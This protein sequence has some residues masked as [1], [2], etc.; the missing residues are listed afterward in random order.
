MVRRRRLSRTARAVLITAAGILFWGIAL[1]RAA[2]IISTV[3]A[4]RPDVW[5]LDWHV[6]A[7]GAAGL[8]DRT[9]HRSELVYP[10]QELPVS[11]FN[12]PPMSA[13]WGVPLAWL[14][15][16]LGGV[17]W[18][19]AGFVA[20]VVGWWILAYRVL[21]LPHGWVWIGLGLAVYSRFSAFDLHVVLGNINDLMFGLLVG[22]TV[23]HAR[24][25]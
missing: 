23:L 12:L 4:E 24:G 2:Y 19:A 9:L 7:A 1:R 25:R 22:F 14:P 10:G 20:W 15:D 16:D 6:Y 13:M 5:L 18:L 21:H 11:N 17:I 8:M 3:V